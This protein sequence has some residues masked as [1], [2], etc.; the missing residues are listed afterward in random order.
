MSDKDK[1]RDAI[2]S[3]IIDEEIESMGAPFLKG[4]QP[5]Q[6][7]TM[8]A[9][10]GVNGELQ[11]YGTSGNL[12]PLGGLSLEAYGQGGSLD[13]M[14]RGIDPYSE[15]GIRARYRSAF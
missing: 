5:V 6:K 8:P 13:Q 9:V 3:S 4:E 14:R 10:P 1:K 11:P 15:Y 7:Y 12:P 2:T